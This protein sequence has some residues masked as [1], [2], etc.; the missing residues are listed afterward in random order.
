MYVK[1][2]TTMDLQSNFCLTPPKG[3]FVKCIQN[4]TKKYSVL[5]LIKEGFSQNSGWE[6][7]WHDP[8]IKKQYQVV[9][10]GAGGHGLATAYY[11][12]KN[13]SHL[14]SKA[15]CNKISFSFLYL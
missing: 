4:L 2:R 8:E 14:R 15:V 10:V 12:A 5:S 9:I 11:L 1:S 3:Y 7:V 13:L 6:R